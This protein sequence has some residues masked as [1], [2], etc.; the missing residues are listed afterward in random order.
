MYHSDFCFPAK[1]EGCHVR[2][3]INALFYFVSCF[4]Q[5]ENLRTLAHFFTLS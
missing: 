1:E 2:S 4:L 5:F 3:A